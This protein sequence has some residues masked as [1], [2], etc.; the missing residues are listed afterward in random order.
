VEFVNTA[1]IPAPRER[2]WD[3]M[4]DIESVG[5]CVPGV[6]RLEALGDDRYRGAMRVK[7]GPIALNL[8]GDL[9]LDERDAST[10]TTRMHA[11][12]A[13]KRVGG[14]VQ[15]RLSL[16][17]NEISPS[18]T[19]LVVR[20]EANVLGRLGEFGQ[21]VMRKKADQIMAEFANNVAR[22]VTDTSTSAGAA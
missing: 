10:G 5:R 2:V 14:S 20:T 21:P 8:E 3:L 19:E 18:E 9:A 13:D 16:Q 7:V 1:R 4:Q 6:E 11:Q 15:A 12:A 22:R 17:A